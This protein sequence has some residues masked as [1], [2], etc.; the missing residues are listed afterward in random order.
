MY[1]RLCFD[2]TIRYFAHCF[3]LTIRYFAHCFDLTI[4]Y[5][6]HCFLLF[7]VGIVNTIILVNLFC[8]VFLVG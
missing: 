7:H 6:A 4:R 8:L 5:F 3:D 1:V 2:L